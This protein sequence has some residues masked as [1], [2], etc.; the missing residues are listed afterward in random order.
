MDGAVPPAGVLPITASSSVSLTSIVRSVKSASSTLVPV[1]AGRGSIDVNRVVPLQDFS[2]PIDVLVGD[3]D[4]HHRRT[5]FDTAVVDG[6]VV[7]RLASEK[8]APEAL[9]SDRVGAGNGG[10]RCESGSGIAAYGVWRHVCRFQI[11][12]GGVCMN[13][14]VV[15]SD[16]D[17]FVIT[18]HLWG[19]GVVQIQ[20]VWEG[21]YW[22]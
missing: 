3:P 9:P 15:H 8:A 19:W 7:V 20:T 12:H 4:C 2:N 11:S 21:A 16:D 17:L 5:A 13:I 18:S 10:A 6:G 14:R 1:D 22:D